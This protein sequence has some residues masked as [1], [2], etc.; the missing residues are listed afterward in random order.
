M[1][2]N[3]PMRLAT[4]QLIL[5]SGHTH[6]R[7]PLTEEVGFMLSREPEK[8]LISWEPVSSRLIT[9]TFRTKQKRTLARFIVCYAPTNKASDEV[10]DH[11]HGRLKNVLGNNRPQR[12]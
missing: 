7:A 2:L 10:K 4:G 9:A 11:F 5:Y 3:G 6:D 8:A 12:E 1:D